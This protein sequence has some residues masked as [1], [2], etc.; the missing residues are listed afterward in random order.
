MISRG[1]VWDIET[2]PILG[3]TWG[4][5]EQ[6]VIEVVE[7]Y[8]VLSVAWQWVGEKKVHCLGQDD[9][10]GFIPGVNDDKELM[11]RIWVLL[12]EA[13]YAVAHNGDQFDVKKVNARFLVHG[14]M[15]PSPYKQIDTKKIAKRV[16]GFTS[17]RL[18]DLAR[19]LNVNQK[20]DPG[21]FA[22][23]KGCM[24]GEPQAWK[25]M[26]KY[27]RQDIP[28]L[29]DLYLQFRA[30]DKQGIAMNTIEGKPDKCPKCGVGVMWPKM[31]YRAT[32]S[33]LYQYYRCADCGGTAKSRVAEPKPKNERNM[34]VS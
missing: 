27:N 11:E 7:D 32:N 2:S 31:K 34:Y 12:D 20:G 19:D 33:N 25:R 21:G 22:T 18:K 4:I 17:N 8:K 10:P 13:D 15:P 26:K 14:M 5:W 28:P 1:L 3:Y 9:M 23:W 24:A 29:M 16:A 6:N 30:W